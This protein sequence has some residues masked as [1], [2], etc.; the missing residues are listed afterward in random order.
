MR[1]PE[2][3]HLLNQTMAG[4]DQETMLNAMRNA[5]RGGSTR[6]S[7]HTAPSGD[8]DGPYRA[9]IFNPGAPPGQN[10]YSEVDLTSNNQSAASGGHNPW[11][12]TPNNQSAA[13][14]ASGS[15]SVAG[16]AH[17]ETLMQR[18]IDQM[19]A[20]SMS[21]PGVA[22][23]STG[24]SGQTAPPR[25]HIPS[26]VTNVP[27]AQQMMARIQSDPEIAAMASQPGVLQR[28]QQMQAAP[29]RIDEMMQDDPQMA[30]L[31]QRITDGVNPET[32]DEW[33]NMGPRD[34]SASSSLMNQLLSQQV[35]A[36]LESDPEAVAMLNQ[37]V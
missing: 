35:T 8:G 13:P 14:T 3:S 17:M 18:M 16:A 15:S 1:D 10:P 4:L 2:L 25:G 34:T 32:M 26:S 11:A 7:N 5:M 19:N 31:M 20:G 37:P 9:W 12:T 21:A 30:A 27:I 36:Q 23:G 24:G 22:T 29:H 33:M 6:E 28:M